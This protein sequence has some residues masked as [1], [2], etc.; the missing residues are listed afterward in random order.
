MPRSSSAS[1]GSQGIKGDI[2]HSLAE[3]IALA[4]NAVI[5][6]VEEHG[7][8]DLVLKF[9]ILDLG[10]RRAELARLQTSSA[11]DMVKQILKMVRH[12][13]EDIVAYLD[14]REDIVGVDLELRFKILDL[15]T[16][17]QVWRKMVM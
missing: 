12:A 16:R 5:A 1:S 9:K 14:G 4:S 17:L 11:L 15:K 10:S 13:E 8:D 7:C 2:Q 6:H 3:H